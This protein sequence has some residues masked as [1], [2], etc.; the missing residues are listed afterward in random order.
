MTTRSKTFETYDKARFFMASLIHAEHAKRGAIE[1][2]TFGPERLADGRYV[3]FYIV[4]RIARP[5]GYGR[6]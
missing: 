5:S 6:R 1:T 4:K 3:V 2:T